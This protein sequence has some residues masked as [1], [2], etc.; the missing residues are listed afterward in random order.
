MDKM[1]KLLRGL[2]DPDSPRPDAPLAAE[3]A[4]RVGDD[5]AADAQTTESSV[6]LAAR[7]EGAMDMEPRLEGAVNT[8]PRLEGVVDTTRQERL[9]RQ[10]AASGR[11]LHELMAAA[12]LV[13]TVSAHLVP[14][15]ADLL[16]QAT[17]APAAR[18]PH[19]RRGVRPHWLWIGGAVLALALAA[20]LV[21]H[22]PPPPSRGQDPLM[23]APEQTRP[24]DAGPHMLPAGN[25]DVVP[26]PPK[27]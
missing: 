12:E 14:A 1:E 15:P 2:L 13:D 7:L 27:P 10:Q 22:R 4:A 6:E 21:L 18:R 25:Q 20:V 3:L 23:A 26:P 24:D 5:M 16:R 8:E 19:P 17:A 9:D 11:A